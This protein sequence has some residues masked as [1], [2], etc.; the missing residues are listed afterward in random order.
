MR[1]GLHQRENM[2]LLLDAAGQHCCQEMQ[3]WY[4]EH[5]IHVVKIRRLKYQLGVIFDSGVTLWRDYELRG[6]FLIAGYGVMGAQA[7]WDECSCAGLGNH[8]ITRYNPRVFL[9]PSRVV[10]YEDLTVLNTGRMYF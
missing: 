8:N 1:L 4:K 7:R 5:R 6:P 3:T 9:D 2:T 10:P